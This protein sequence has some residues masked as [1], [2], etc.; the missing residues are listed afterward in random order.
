MMDPYCVRTTK[1]P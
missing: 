1:C